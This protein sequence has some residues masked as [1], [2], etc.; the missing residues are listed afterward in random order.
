MVKTKTI[1]V[2][3]NCTA[4]FVKWEG[5]CSSCG[6]WN[7]L[8]P[9]EVAKN[10]SQKVVKKPKFSK[11][12]NRPIPI[13]HISA[14]NISRYSIEFDT[15][16]SRVLGGGIVPGSIVLIG[17]QPGIGKSTLMLQL[18][19][20]SAVKV[21]YVSGEE[22]PYQIKM[23]AERINGNNPNCSI[24]AEIDL[25]KILDTA[26]Q[27]Q[28]QILMIDSIQTV[29]TK[30]IESTAGSVSQIKEC[31]SKLQQ[32]A[33]HTNI[34]VFIIGHINK[35]G[36]IAGPKILEHIVDVV[37]QFEGDR[38]YVYRIL[39]TIKNRFGSTDEIGIYEM[40]Q[41]G[42]RPVTNPSELLLSQSEENLSGSAVACTMEGAR[43]L[44]I[45]TQAL[46]ST[47]IFGTPQ[48][49]TTGFDVR[50]MSM[51]L[52]VLEKKCGLYFSQNDVFLNLAGGI[53][54][55]D[56]AIDLSIIAAL[57][58]SLNDIPIDKK[59]SFAAEIGLSGEVRSVN[60]IE[61]RIQEAARLGFNQIF[62]SKHHKKINSR[63]FNNIEVKTIGKVE[64]LLEALFT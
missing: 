21:L 41:T 46:V 42:L 64:D 32:F 27:E 17:G 51:L 7:T 5:K 11:E 44:M 15:E 60:R 6:E 16:L 55:T 37:L 38:N 25:D 9:K 49:S 2:C 28:P 63:Q 24:L 39:R 20:K 35:E 22:S 59:I 4:Q 12:E 10:S 45:E 62:I 43:P 58:S 30:E 18:A 50:R 8:E 54:V 48:R 33:K 34:P 13:N 56:P 31:T 1:H 61:Q 26:Y 19:S 23:R 52:A 47:A 3:S 14:P 29:F 57:I 36:S 40:E 53:K